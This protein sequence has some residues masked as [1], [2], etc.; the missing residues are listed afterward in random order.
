MVRRTAR[1]FAPFPLTLTLSLREREQRASRSGKPAGL[2]RSPRR[3]IVREKQERRAGGEHGIDKLHR[4][5]NQLVF[6]V[7]HA[8]HFVV[9]A[10]FHGLTSQ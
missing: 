8:V 6:P 4:A 7:N 9:I 1:E 5:G 3:G 10:C 2:D